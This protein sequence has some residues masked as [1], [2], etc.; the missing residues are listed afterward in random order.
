MVL[1]VF[2][3]F[4]NIAMRVDH[5]VKPF[6]AAIQGGRKKQSNFFQTFFF[7]AVSLESVFLITQ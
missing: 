1:A 6:L 7:D 2:N 3:I 4:L 5:M